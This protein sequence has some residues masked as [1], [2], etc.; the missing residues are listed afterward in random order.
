MILHNEVMFHEPCL[1][2]IEEYHD[3][4]VALQLF[5]KN[6]PHEPMATATVWV[7]GLNRN[8]IAI[9]DYSENEGMLQALIKANIVTIPHHRRLEG[10]TSVPICYLTE[11][12]MEDMAQHA[13]LIYQL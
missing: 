4:S 12:V 8:E 5:C 6:A 2:S 10:F 9:K 7:P 3:G 13:N 11:T 1:V